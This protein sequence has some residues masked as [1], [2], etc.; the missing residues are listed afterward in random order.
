MASKVGQT[1]EDLLQLQACLAGHVAPLADLRGRHHAFLHSLLISRG[2]SPTDA[3]DLLA[4]LWGDCVSGGEE[5]PSL[6]EKFSGK[7]SLRTWLV[8]VAMNRLY[9]L[10][11]KQRPSPDADSSPPAGALENAVQSQAATVFRLHESGLV[12]LLRHSLQE[13]FDRCPAVEL[14]MLR[15]VYLH[16]LTQRE[17][18]RMWGWHEAKV[19]RHLAQAMRDIEEATLGRLKRTDPWMTLAWQ[20]FVDLCE[21][22]QIGFV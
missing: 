17:V 1:D 19:S 9:D 13:A 20:D 11:R 2:A 21:T 8:S 12:E 7:S 10:K 3:E 15:L 6:L 18:G 22:H 5:R 4:D 14:L 16:G